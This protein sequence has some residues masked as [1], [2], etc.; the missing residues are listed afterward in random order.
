MVPEPEV[1]QELL[2]VTMAHVSSGVGDCDGG[3]TS[4]IIGHSVNPE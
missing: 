1:N 4:G 3:G 2:V